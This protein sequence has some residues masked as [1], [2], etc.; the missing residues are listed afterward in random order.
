MFDKDPKSSV[1]EEIIDLMDEQMLSRLK[2]KGAPDQ[3]IKAELEVEALPKDGELPTP[4]ADKSDAEGLDAETLRKLMEM[5]EQ[6]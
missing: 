3:G 4:D 1:L 2:K 5:H 6:E